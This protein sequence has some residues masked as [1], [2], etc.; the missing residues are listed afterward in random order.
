M[1]KRQAPSNGGSSNK[2]AKTALGK[3]TVN[4]RTTI[5]NT[6]PS[7]YRPIAPMGF[8]K[9]M[10]MK[11]KYVSVHSLSAASGI[12]TKYAYSCNGLYDPD[13][14]GVGHQP[15][16]FDQ[17]M[18]I[19]NHYHVLKS[20]ITVTFTPVTTAVPA[21]FGVFIDDD[22]ITSLTNWEHFAEQTNTSYKISASSTDRPYVI[23]KYW[24][25]EAAFG[26]QT[27]LSNDEL[28]GYNGANPVEQSSFVIFLKPLD[29]S[30]TTNVYAAVEIEYLSVFTELKEQ[31]QS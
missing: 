23:T 12:L 11:L 20:K 18:G 13:T 19:Y 30:T 29:F 27:I 22:A 26:K 10:T 16:Y 6:T 17:I 31:T 8:P 3:S 21:A 24:D 25:A 4:K 15:L 2:L 5:R 1:K 14:S 28:S 9:T 7:I